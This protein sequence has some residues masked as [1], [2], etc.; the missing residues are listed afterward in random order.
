MTC[1]ISPAEAAKAT[2]Q[3]LAYYPTIPAMDPQQFAAGLTKLLST[4]PSPVVER[5]VDPVDGIP[6]LV[7][8]L[9]LAKIRELLDTWR[10]EHIDR[11]ERLA[12]ITR[13]VLPSLPPLPDPETRKR[14]TDGFRKLSEHLT[15]R[16]SR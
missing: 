2:A 6:A 8:F 7:E 15:V 14:V 1:G 12:A 5:A 16:N 4:F 13:K 3:I 9:S 11:Q 10:R